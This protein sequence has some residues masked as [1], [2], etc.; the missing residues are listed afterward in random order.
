M[1]LSAGS[2]IPKYMEQSLASADYI[3]MYA[4]PLC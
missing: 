4:Q 1:E 2:D 3:I